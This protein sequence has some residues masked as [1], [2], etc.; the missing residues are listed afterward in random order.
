MCIGTLFTVEKILPRAWLH[1]ATSRPVLNPLSYRGSA[2]G[3]RT[4]KGSQHTASVF[5]KNVLC[6]INLCCLPISSRHIWTRILTLL[7][8]MPEVL[9][10]IPSLATYLDRIS[11]LIQERQLSVTGESMCT[12]CPGSVVRLT[13][14]PD[15]T[16]AVY[17]GHK[18]QQNYMHIWTMKIWYY[19]FLALWATALTIAQGASYDLMQYHQRLLCWGQ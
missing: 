5:I 19:Y 16:F 6:H 10:L 1:L 2:M 15:M 17:H 7:T 8:P 18:Q 11:F 12:T 13:D 3:E 9:G 14:H 4:Y